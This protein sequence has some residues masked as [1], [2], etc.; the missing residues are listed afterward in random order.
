MT[1]LAAY[2]YWV[3]VAVWTCVLVFAFWYSRNN[4]KIFGTVRIL[5]IVLIIDTIRDIVENIYFGMYFG[6][7][8]GVF[9][10]V[11]V[12]ILGQPLL[13]LTPKLLNVAA[14]LII[15]FVLFLHW[16]PA[17]AR[18]RDTLQRLATIDRMTGLSNRAQYLTVAEVELARSRRYDR[19]LSML[20]LDID[21]FKSI[22]D[23]HGHD[24]GDKVIIEVARLCQAI[25]RSTDIVARLGGEEFGI[26]LPE[27]GEAEAI[28]FAE[29]LR[30]T[31]ADMSVAL[32]GGR[33]SG[34]VSIGVATREGG[35]GVTEMMKRADLALYEAKHGGRNRVALF[36]LHAPQADPAA[37]PAAA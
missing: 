9:D 36:D 33:L 19:P 30:V 21:H 29:R 28:A 20:M 31:I 13:L 11:F 7:Q 5:L 24:I 18:E 35:G 10:H 3:I 34:T 8:Y 1:S 17:A 22:N 23:R 16:M 26:M 25:A 27:T 32:P 6:S 15:L 37:D 2:I 4:I 14:G 12:T